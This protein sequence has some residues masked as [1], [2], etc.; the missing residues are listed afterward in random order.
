MRTRQMNPSCV[1]GRWIRFA[2]PADESVLRILQIDPSCVPRREKIGLLE[3]STEN[4]GAVVPENR[5][6][7]RRKSMSDIF[8]YLDWR[9]DIPFS[10]DPFNEV[11]ALVLAE[12]SYVDFSEIVPGAMDLNMREPDADEL[13]NQP[14]MPAVS[15]ETACSRFWDRHTEEEIRSSRTLFSKTP[16]LLKKM[17]S[18]ARFGN[19]KLTAYVNY[20][21]AEQSLQISAVTCLLDDGSIFVAF[22]GTD[23]TL[24]G[25]KEDFS[26]SFGNETGGQR[27]AAKYLNVLSWYIG[28]EIP[29]RVGG[30]SKGGNLAVFASAFCDRNMKNRITQIYSF[31]SPGFS[32]EIIRD[33]KMQEIFPKI[34]SYV[35]EETIFGLLL[36]KGFEYEVVKST[37]KG[38]W[39][40]DALTWKIKRNRLERAEAVS[41]MSFLLEKSI[42]SWIKKLPVEER[43]ELV[44]II[45]STLNESGWENLSEITS[46]QIRNISGLLR[47]YHELESGD[48]RFLWETVGKLA[49]SGAKSLSEELQVKLISQLLGK[50]EIRPEEELEDQQEA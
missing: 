1:S 32:D 39:Q 25:W 12:L 30:H 48:K 38:I 7:L 47:A 46:D 28:S 8:D 20:V 18:G 16:F 35:P 3:Y 50:D 41:K 45:F 26:F 31:D 24:I 23:D 2:Y 17:C 9:G 22:R 27:R 5:L 4:A 14:Q 43:K 19:M 21:S 37:A 36:E 34:Y 42:E 15:I 44:D 6:L 49:V 13:K 11:D 10:A 29:V 40:H 33:T